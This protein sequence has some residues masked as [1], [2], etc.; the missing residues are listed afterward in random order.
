MDAIRLATCTYQEF[1]PHMG[2][3]VRTT[4]GHPRFS[5]PYQLAGHARLIT[6]TR[7]LLKINAE[8]AYEFSYRRL[9]NGNGLENIRR[10]LATIA[11]ASGSDGPLVLLCFDRFD[12]LRPRTPGAIAEW[13]PPG[14]P[15]RPAKK[16]PSWAPSR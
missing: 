9:L 6:P 8:D 14:G 13:R 1:A 15:S 16:C 5:L 4:A 11:A 2:T 7:E 10:E 3:P 12:K